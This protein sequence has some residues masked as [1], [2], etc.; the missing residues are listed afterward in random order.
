MA[1]TKVTYSMIEGAAVSVADFGAVGDGVANDGV[2][3]QAA[4]DSL[5]G[6][7]VLYFPPGIYAYTAPTNEGLTLTDVDNITILGYGAT[8]R[9]TDAVGSFNKK[10]MTITQCDGANVV[11]L[12]VDNNGSAYFGG[13]SIYDS[14]D[15]IVRD[16]RFYDSNPDPVETSDRYGFVF[17]DNTLTTSNFLMTGCS[18]D[19]LQTDFFGIN[20]RVTENY[21]NRP[22]NRCIGIVTGG[23]NQVRSG[24]VITGNTFQNSKDDCVS[25]GIDPSSNTN[26]Q[27][28]NIVITNNTYI[29]T[30]AS[31][32]HFVA[33]NAIGSTNTVSNVVISNNTM[34]DSVGNP[35]LRLDSTNNSNY[36]RHIQVVNNVYKSTAAGGAFTKP[37]FFAKRTQEGQIC[38]NSIFGDNIVDGMYFTNIV[39]MTITGNQ[40]QATGKAFEIDET[41]NSFVG[42]QLFKNN[43]WMGSPTTKLSLPTG[44]NASD[45]VEILPS[46]IETVTISGAGQTVLAAGRRNFILTA[47]APSDLTDLSNGYPGQ[48]LTIFFDNNNVTVTHGT[49]VN[50]ILLAGG[51]D[52]VGSTNDTLTIVNR[53]LRWYEVSRT[54][55]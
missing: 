27:I 4:L 8:L 37:V 43:S 11:G 45:L 44:L 35:F 40:A 16:C 21:F 13:F 34:I 25:I 9:R 46:D 39:R 20:V 48:V 12:I 1:L 23:S 14:K 33:L 55:I 5:T 24:Y 2:A 22:I 52:F 29:S 47:A 50:K 26:S 18:F 17:G 32:G 41:L 7:Q 30:I 3:L 19:G 10:P 6:D 38:N 15:C 54:V 42:N 49:G 53:D 31:G 28:T 36:S 51:T